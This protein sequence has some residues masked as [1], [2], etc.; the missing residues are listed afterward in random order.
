M[1]ATTSD[2]QK[3]RDDFTAQTPSYRREFPPRINPDTGDMIR[4]IEGGYEKVQGH[5]A[6]LEDEFG[7]LD[8]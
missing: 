8:E 7:R 4:Q 6:W 3:A 1:S 2:S 5:L